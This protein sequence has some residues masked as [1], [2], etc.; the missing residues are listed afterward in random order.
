MSV[1]DQDGVELTSASGSTVLGH[2]LNSALR[3]R[4]GGVAFKKGDLVTPGSIGPRLQPRPGLTATV[5]FAG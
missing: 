5:T 2:R 1:K 3:L 4:K